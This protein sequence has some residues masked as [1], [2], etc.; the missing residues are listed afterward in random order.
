MNDALHDRI[1]A[2]LDGALDAE[3]TRRFEQDL[4]NDEVASEFREALLLRDLL[5]DLPPDLPPPGLVARIEATLVANAADDR[6]QE[7]IGRAHV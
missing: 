2:Y 7:Q 4:L 3:Q 6:P 5:A 1:E